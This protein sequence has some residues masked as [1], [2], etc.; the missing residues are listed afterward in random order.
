MENL[1]TYYREASA[2]FDALRFDQSDEVI[3][4]VKWFTSAHECKGSK[5][6]DVGCGT[7]RYTRAFLDSGLAAIGMDNSIDQL[8]QAVYKVPVR[9][10]SASSLPF[11]AAEFGSI[12]HIMM[13]HQIP[14]EELSVALAESLR[15]LRDRGHL[16]IKTCSHSDLARR[17]FNQLFPEALQINE[18][19]Y[20]DTHVLI[21]LLEEI[22]FTLMRQAEMEDSYQMTGAEIKKRLSAKHNSTLFLMSEA[23]FQ[24]GIE[25]AEGTLIDEQPYELSHFHTLLEFQ[26]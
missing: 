1:R 19:R 21:E 11:G 20:L 12:S 24:R 25:R 7:G 5:H 10:G 13:L 15:A 6:L 17:P 8:M 22:G 23:G 14:K 18:V 26:K 3:R 2:S 4:H 16:W 9:H